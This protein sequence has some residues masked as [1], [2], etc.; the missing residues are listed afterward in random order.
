MSD[1]VEV[2]GKTERRFVTLTDILAPKTPSVT[3]T[4]R[5]PEPRTSSLHCSWNQ[6]RWIPSQVLAGALAQAKDARRPPRG[7]GEAIDTPTR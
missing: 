1:D 6:A 7:H 4:S 5:S 2:D 3:W